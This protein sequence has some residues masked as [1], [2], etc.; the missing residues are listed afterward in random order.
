MRILIAI[1][2]LLSG[3]GDRNEARHELAVPWALSGQWLVADLHTHT[4]FSDGRLSVTELVTRAVANECGVLAI[5]DHGDP[6]VKSVSPEFFEE[7]DALRRQ[8]PNLVLLAGLEWNVPPYGG[9]EH[10]NLIVHPHIER[11][12]LSQFKSLYDR[13]RG[14]PAHSAQQAMTWLG[15]ITKDPEQRVLI[16]NHPLR[17]SSAT[18]QRA[19]TDLGAWH[20]AGGILVGFEGAPG[21]QR[22]GDTGAYSKSNPPQDRWDPMVAQIG[23]AW[24]RLLARGISLWGA[25]ANS[26][27]HNDEWD[28]EPCGF[29][30]THL[31][32]P[33]RSAKG[34]LQAIR[35]GTFWAGHGRVLRHL[36][37]TVNAPGLTV[38]ASP[39]ESIRHRMGGEVSV[40]IVAERTATAVDRSLVAEVI[41]N[42]R[43][44][45]VESISRVTLEP[46]RSEAELPSLTLALGED[47][48]SCYLRARV[49]STD[50]GKG[51]LLAYTNPVRIRMK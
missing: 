8:L 24:D 33:E 3:C 31:Q 35:A 5:T 39:G 28:E 12:V 14:S 34:T 15:S 51:D 2:L 44:G 23:G 43:T 4:R 16:Y 7:V 42:C 22:R 47:G 19:E 36:T 10:V 50:A 17:N 21:H 20:G 6:R 26:D 11:T 18:P 46:G 49:R 41:G 40:R 48:A 9:R 32:V 29:S 37:F 45:K 25:I 1:A 13:G 30:R 38:P 27:Y